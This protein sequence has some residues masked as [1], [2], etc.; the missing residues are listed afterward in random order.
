M[1]DKNCI[2]SRTGLSK[3]YI[4]PYQYIVPTGLGYSKVLKTGNSVTLKP[5]N[6]ETL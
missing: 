3:N 4:F 6:L 1:S 5:C 2:S